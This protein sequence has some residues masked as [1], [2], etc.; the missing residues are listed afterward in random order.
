MTLGSIG[1]G[2]RADFTA[3]NRSIVLYRLRPISARTEQ[4]R[5]DPPYPSRRQGH[6]HSRPGD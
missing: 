1:V 6:W 3:M 4:R 5:C 2:S